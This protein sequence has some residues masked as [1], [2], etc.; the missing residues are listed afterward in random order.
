MK[1]GAARAAA[2][3]WVAE[4]T[5]DAAW[6]RGAYVS[7]STTWLPDDAE[8]PLGSDVDVMV[9]TGQDAAPPK[10]GKVGYE[11]VL[12]E[13]TYLPLAQIASAEQVLANLHL[14]SGFRTDTVIADPTGHLRRLYGE[15]SRRFA[16]PV[17]VR[18]RCEHARRRI[19]EGLRT[20]D[21]SAPFHDQV[22]Q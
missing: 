7:G 5:R 12:V 4:H 2:A 17:W 18:R 15:V 3:R 21:T 10:L 11:G 19:E 16:E 9:V 22:T 1:V 14:A 20:I 13:V 8:L 6:F